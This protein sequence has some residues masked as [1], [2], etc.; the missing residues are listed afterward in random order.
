[1]L[2]RTM[3]RLAALG[4]WLLVAVC[5]AYW[6]FKLLVQPAPV[7][8]QANTLSS[9]QAL[10]GDLTRLLGAEPEPEAP[11]VVAAASR[12]RLIGV[13]APR[14]P[15][16]AAEGLALITVDGKPARAYR[17]GAVIE[18]DL[19]L[20]RVRARGADLGARG[21]PAAS[22]ALDVAPLPPAATGVPG[23]APGLP[24]AVAVRPLPNM[25]LR[26][27][28]PRLSPSGNEIVNGEADDGT[29]DDEMPAAAPLRQGVQ[30]Q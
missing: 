18:G 12:F 20:Q 22:V 24:P 6:G 27:G 15:V 9:G 30:T 3:T 7:P 13:V 25:A 28:Q 14:S 29:A 11:V 26:P 21:A 16:A 2:A 8:P 10:R 4:V 19:V 23:A 17:V 1:M 5:A